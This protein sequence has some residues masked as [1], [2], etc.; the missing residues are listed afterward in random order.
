VAITQTVTLSRLEVFPAIPAPTPP[1]PDPPEPD[2][3]YPTLTVILSLTFD[4]PS[5]DYLPAVSTDVK[6]FAY[7][8]GQD[9]SKM[10]E[11]VPT[12]AAA[13]WPA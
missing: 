8:D 9:I 10:P 5:D 2:P 11:P 4:D 13:I 7:G 3:T 1:Q 12:I 6:R